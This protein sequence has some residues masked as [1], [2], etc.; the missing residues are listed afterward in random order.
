M[1]KPLIQRSF[2]L[3]AQSVVNPQ[4]AFS[5]LTEERGFAVGFFLN[6]LKWVLCEFYVYYLFKTDQVLF[7]EPWLNIPV[8]Q[9]RYYELFFYIPYGIIAWIFT[10]GVVQTIS[11]A[12]GGKG[13]FASTLNIVGIMIFTPFVFIDTIDALFMI[14]NAGDWNIVFNS[15]TRTIYV[16]WSGVLLVFGLLEIHELK[17]AKSAI[18]AFF[19][20]PLTI[21]VNLI[22]VR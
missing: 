8:E 3:F 14:I 12:L 18:I 7:I 2:Y 21:F 5:L 9:Y 4:R 10:A 6:T 1:Q 15:I 13:T 20:I 17:A 16:L 19:V 22:F 11:N